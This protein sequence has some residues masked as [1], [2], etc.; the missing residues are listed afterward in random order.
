MDQNGWFRLEKDKLPHTKTRTNNRNSNLP[1]TKY[2]CAHLEEIG[3]IPVMPAPQPNQAPDLETVNQADLAAF[4]NKSNRDSSQA[5]PTT[6]MSSLDKDC[7]EM[8]TQTCGCAETTDTEIIDSSIQEADSAALCLQQSDDNHS[9]PLHS[10]TAGPCGPVLT[11]DIVLHETLE[12]FVHKKIPE[13]AV[14]TKGYGASGTFTAYQSMEKYTMLCFLQKEGLETPVRV[15]FSLAASNKGTPDTGRNVR[16]FS[17]KFYTKD[18]IFDLLC[19]HIPVFLVRDAIRFPEAIQAFLPSP[20]NNLM[21]PNRFW[22]F[23]ARAPE[24]THFITWL[25]SDAGTVKSFRHMRSSS[26]NTYVWK[27]AAGERR[28]VKYHWLPKAGEQYIDQAESKRLSAADPDYAGRDL[29]QA[30]ANSHPVEYELHVQ[31]MEPK[32][33]AALP[34]DPL[35]DTK[36]WDECQFP[37]IPVGK[38][39]LTQNTTDYDAQVE[40]I[41]FS[42]AN[43]LEGAEL[44]NDKMLQSRSF[45][46]WDAQRYR[47]GAHFRSIPVNAQADWSAK[48]AI[49]S[50]SGTDVSGTI[51]RSSIPRE[52]NFIQA[53]ERY[54]SLT[55]MQKDHLIDNIASELYLVP[56]EIRTV[57]LEYF[58]SASEAMAQRIVKQMEICRQKDL[59]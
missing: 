31:F 14:H 10:Q 53:G 48:E 6:E 11:Q 46:Y 17:A 25:Y 57:I 50:G 29:Y 9:Q 55:E 35:D 4:T 51:G 45:I 36:I 37:L 21:D 7:L 39:S 2:Y 22:D 27:N 33:E 12:S 20:Q 41:A 19:N 44:S 32:D 3:V 58:R 54:R 42:P 23:A 24:A 26:V 43:L 13:R 1:K 5:N 40:R 8:S 47:L 30:I 49:T 59:K 18:G 16:G 52:E 56:L 28:Y 15:R 38:L 34:Y